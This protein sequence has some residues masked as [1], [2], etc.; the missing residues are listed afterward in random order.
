MKT[1]A[2]DIQELVI[3]IT[4]LEKQNRRWKTGGLLILA[5]FTLLL[6]ANARAQKSG[7]GDSTR[8][9]LE[10]QTFKLK[11]ADGTLRGLLGVADGKA[12]LELYDRAGRVTWSTATR[13]SDAGR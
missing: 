13:V 11:D 3:R 9:T 4:E 2:F 5:V 1:S 12:N 7:Q 8:K 6:T 10:A